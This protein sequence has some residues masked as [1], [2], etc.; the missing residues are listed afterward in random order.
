VAQA[1]NVSV[2]A[3]SHGVLALQLMVRHTVHVYKDSMWSPTAGLLIAI[4]T[5]RLDSGVTVWLEMGL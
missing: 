5:S 2:V 1:G 4:P 3:A